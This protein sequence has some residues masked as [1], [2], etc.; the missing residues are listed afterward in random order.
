MKIIPTSQQE[1]YDSNDINAQ[2]ELGRTLL[3]KAVLNN[4]IHAAVAAVDTMNADLSIKDNLG[5]SAIDYAN[6]LDVHPLFRE[7]VKPLP[8]I[9]PSPSPYPVKT[10]WQRMKEIIGIQK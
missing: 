8:S 5:K 6:E 4:D 10:C 9:T 1:M 3:I 2:D 7:I